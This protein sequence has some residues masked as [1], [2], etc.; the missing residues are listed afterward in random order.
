MQCKEL[1]QVVGMSMNMLG[2]LLLA[3]FAVPAHDLNKDGTSGLGLNPDD[4]LK[5]KRI[6]RYW[7]YFSLTLLAYL[8]LFLGFG[9]QMGSLFI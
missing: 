3:F 9:F 4:E 6:R 5:E 8:L 7:I 2:V 1:L